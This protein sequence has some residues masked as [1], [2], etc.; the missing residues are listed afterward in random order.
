MYRSYRTFAVHN[1]NLTV[2]NLIYFLC[3]H[4]SSTTPFIASN[5]IGLSPFFLT[6]NFKTLTIIDR[7]NLQRVFRP[8]LPYLFGFFFLSILLINF[9][10]FSTVLVFSE[11]IL[12]YFLTFLIFLSAKSGP[13]LA[14]CACSNALRSRS[15]G[16]FFGVIFKPRNHFHYRFALFMLHRLKKQNSTAI[17][18]RPEGAEIASGSLNT[19]KTSSSK[20]SSASK[21]PKFLTITVNVEAV[22]LK[23]DWNPPCVWLPKTRFT[24]WMTHSLTESIGFND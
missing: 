1:S 13:Y 7:K 4:T 24:K 9:G 22:V 18:A 16:R 20:K 2:F 8:T 14:F 5:L 17:Q 12:H 10:H 15:R 19:L 21:N 11:I 3:A 23:W 6:L